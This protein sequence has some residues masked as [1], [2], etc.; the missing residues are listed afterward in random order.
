MA[1][2]AGVGVDVGVRVGV[3]VGVE[4][5]AV[6]AVV[7]KTAC[8]ARVLVVGAFLGAAAA[9]SP[10]AAEAEA[11]SAEETAP[12]EGTALGEGSVGG[13]IQGLLL[14]S[15]SAWPL[16]FPSSPEEAGRRAI[17]TPT[18]TMPRRPG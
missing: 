8:G 15:G 18:A 6:R 16:F 14:G 9:V 17:P 13:W 5:A 7:A 11:V 2:A 3:G 1:A 12:G 4:G 10:G